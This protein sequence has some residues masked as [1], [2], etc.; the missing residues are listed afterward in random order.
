MYH[1]ILQ[2]SVYLFKGRHDCIQNSVMTEVDFTIKGK[3]VPLQEV[4]EA[5]L[6]FVTD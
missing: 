5:V 6:F 3:N 4:K 2:T 1:N